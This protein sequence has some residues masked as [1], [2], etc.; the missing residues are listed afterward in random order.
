MN[1]TNETATRALETFA[2]D[3]VLWALAAAA[4]MLATILVTTW[5]VNRSW[6]Q[7]S[8][9]KFRELRNRR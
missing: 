8:N 2:N 7:L 3:P 9:R 6:L 5:L 1:T 4:I